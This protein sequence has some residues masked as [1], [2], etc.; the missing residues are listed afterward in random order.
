MGFESQT[1]GTKT[2]IAGRYLNRQLTSFKLNVLFLRRRKEEEERERELRR[3]EKLRR[4]EERRLERERRRRQHRQEKKAREEERKMQM[5]IA[6]EERRILIAQRKLET[7]RL[8]SELFNRIK[9][10][11]TDITLI[12]IYNVCLL[13]FDKIVI[14]WIMTLCI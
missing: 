1:M 4:R 5:K 8:L 7:I 3:E 12:I 13:M 10:G 11:E 9:V 2:R 6:L 14:H